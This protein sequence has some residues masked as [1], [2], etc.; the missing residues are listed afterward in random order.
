[1]A[2]RSPSSRKPAR[3]PKRGQAGTGSAPRPAGEPLPALAQL[4]LA[5]A[6]LDDAIAALPRKRGR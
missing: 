1:M 3:K 2:R 6:K 4:K 5:R